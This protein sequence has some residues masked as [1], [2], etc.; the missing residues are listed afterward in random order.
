M[1]KIFLIGAGP[2]DPELLTLKAFRLIREAD[3]ILYDSLVDKRIVRMARR[4]ARRID[5]GKRCGKHSAPQAAISQ[6]LV[7]EGMAGHRVVRLKAATR[8]FLAARPRK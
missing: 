1:T 4:G 6:L 8:W 2:G 7:A 5:V 3:V